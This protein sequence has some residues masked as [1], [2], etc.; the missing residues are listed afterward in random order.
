MKYYLLLA[1]SVFCLLWVVGA[2]AAD[3]PAAAPPAAKAAA[4]VPRCATP[5]PAARKVTLATLSNGLT[6]I[7]Q[8]NHVAPVATVRCFVKNTGSAYEGK[9]LGAGLEPRAGARRGRRH[10]PPIAAKRRSRRS[11]TPS[12]GP[13]TPPPRPT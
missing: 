3:K 12:A 2:V 6:V 9:H 5:A 8:E 4:E 10:A 1:V 7:V 11:S 13:R